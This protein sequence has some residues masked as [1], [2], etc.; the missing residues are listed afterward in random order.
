VS[1]S[2]ILSGATAVGILIALGV[3]AVTVGL[4][5]S[6]TTSNLRTLTATGPAPP[7]GGT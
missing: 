4:I 2:Q 6:E 7:P 3:L 5:R 1:L